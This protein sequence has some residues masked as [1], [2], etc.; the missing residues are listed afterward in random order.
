MQLDAGRTVATAG[1]LGQI[2]ERRVGGESFSSIA[3]ALNR[4]G[5]SG[6][7]GGRWYASSVREYMQRRSQLNRV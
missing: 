6:N 5:I 3:A 1:L 7:Y 4:K 2:N